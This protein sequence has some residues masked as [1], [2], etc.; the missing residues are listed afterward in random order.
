MEKTIVYYYSKKGN[1][2]FLAEKI[3]DNLKCDI[4]EIRP[5]LNVF[6]LILV[7][8]TAGIRKLKKLPESYDRVILCGPV[9][10]GK[11]IAPLKQFL[12]KYKKQIHE[13]VFVTCCGSGFEQKDKKF[14]HG[15][16]FNLIREMLGDKCVHCEAFPITMV[17]PE[18]KREDPDSVMKTR[19]SGENFKDEIAERFA[20]FIKSVSS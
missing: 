5:R 7:G 15:L 3:A 20:G 8:F 13:L 9:F 19:L 2:R 1:N 4:E 11:F 12:A 18:D 16:V 6:I 17:V 14:G 10:V